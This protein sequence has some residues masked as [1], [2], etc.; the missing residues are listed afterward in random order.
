MFVRHGKCIYPIEKCENYVIDLSKSAA[1]SGQKLNK[2][3]VRLQTS[4]TTIESP[5]VR[6]ENT[7]EVTLTTITGSNDM[8]DIILDDVNVTIMSPIN[9]VHK[10]PGESNLIASRA[11][12]S[13]TRISEKEIYNSMRTIRYS[14]TEQC[15]QYEKVDGVTT[16][17]PARS[18][19]Q[20]M[21]NSQ[22]SAS[23]NTMVESENPAPISD[24]R[25]IVHGS[26]NSNK[27]LAD[28]DIGHR[29]Y[30]AKRTTA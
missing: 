13:N 12:H 28:R 27:G 10:V 25:W 23:L 1:R 16:A 18:S 17:Q 2:R 20:T 4:Q 19:E 5:S 14:D 6:N 9:T 22:N 8:D 26:C 11:V 21:T 3:N 30:N 7:S 24:T 29:E 15:Q